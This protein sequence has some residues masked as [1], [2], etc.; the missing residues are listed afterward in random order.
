MTPTEDV[1]D[2][3]SP[4]ANRV[5]DK[6]A[7]NDPQDG[8]LVSLTPTLS[9]GSFYDPDEDDHAMTQYQISTSEDF[10]DLIFHHASR[11]YLTGL[12]LFEL[13]LDPETLYYWRVRFIDSHN[14]ASQWSETRFFITKGYDE[15]GDGNGNGVPDIQELDDHVD[16]DENGIPDVEQA[17]MLGVS[18]TD[19]LNPYFVI[20][21]PS[22]DVRI[23]GAQA[24]ELNLLSLV[25][26]QPDNMSGI[27]SFKL[28]L[29]DDVSTTT[30]RTKVIFRY[31]F[32]HY[33]MGAKGQLRAAQ[34]W[35]NWPRHIAVQRY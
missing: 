27:I 29:A 9:T 7:L 4:A 3:I 23:V 30:I 12:N 8:A 25:S 21:S 35:L 1:D 10:S 26:N 34:M 17:D 16:F 24:T 19:T 33:K 31:C 5:P 18:T 2:P 32:R 6:P 14:G 28:H 11:V 20:Q 22:Q 13:L 15:V